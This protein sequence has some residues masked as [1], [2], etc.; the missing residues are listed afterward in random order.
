MHE[1][2]RIIIRLRAIPIAMAAFISIGCGVAVTVSP[3]QPET[4]E[5][6]PSA[7]MGAT[8]AAIETPTPGGARCT[9]TDSNGPE[10][11]GERVTTGCA[12]GQTCV[13]DATAGYSCTGTC[14]AL[15][16]SEALVGT[17]AK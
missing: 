7:G 8:P 16:T 15:P 9:I 4:V 12:E 5:T 17:P 10:E 14:T 1:K 13:C 2:R 11:G 6:P 3:S